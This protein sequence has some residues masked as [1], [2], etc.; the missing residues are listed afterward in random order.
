[1][2]RPAVKR[3]RE[4]KLVAVLD[5]N[6]E[7]AR[8]TQFARTPTSPEADRRKGLAHLAPYRDGGIFAS[9]FSGTGGWE[10]H[11]AGDEIVYIV[12]GATML[13]LMTQQGPQE[14]E[15]RAGMM[16]VVPQGLWH[17]FESPA[18]VTLMS[19]T[20]LPTDHPEVDVED[21]R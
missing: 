9:K 13:R 18:G 10:R 4:E 7:L 15:L 6:A 19:V 14:Q 16:V 8:L 17:R 2:A 3:N 12:E 11:P 1:L 5:F 20:P 21:P